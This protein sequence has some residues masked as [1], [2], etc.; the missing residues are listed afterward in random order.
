MTVAQSSLPMCIRHENG[1][2]MNFHYVEPLNFVV[3]VIIPFLSPSYLVQLNKIPGN[4]RACLLKFW[5]PGVKWV[6]SESHWSQIP[7]LTQHCWRVDSPRSY[8]PTPGGEAEDFLLLLSHSPK[9]RSLVG[10]KL[11]LSIS[12]LKLRPNIRDT[13]NLSWLSFGP[14]RG[15]K[16]SRTPSTCARLFEGYPETFGS[17]VVVESRYEKSYK[18]IILMYFFHYLYIFIKYHSFMTSCCYQ[19]LY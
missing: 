18:K 15:H 13:W 9:G 6:T 11:F 1:G 14:A 8:A 16:M 5:G 7:P 4:V 19:F 17:F 10:L 3:V 2:E 12:I